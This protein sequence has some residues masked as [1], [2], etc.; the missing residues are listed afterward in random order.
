MSDGPPGLRDLQRELAGLA[1]APATVHERAQAVLERLGRMLPFDAAWLAVR[2]PELGRHSPLATTGPAGPL[3]RYFRTPEADAEVDRLGLNGRRPPMLVGE[4]PVPLPELRA[5]AE[6]LLP[7][8]F[9]GGLAAGLFTT[10]GRHVGFLSLLSEDPDRPDRPHRDVVAAVTSIIADGLDRTRQISETARVVAAATAGVVLTRGGEVLRLPGLPDHRLLTRGS[11]VLSTATRELGGT[12]ALISF[13]VPDR[14]DGGAL[15][16]VTALDC[17][18]P[19]L[20]HLAAAV[21]LGPPGDLRGLTTLDL[22]VLGLLVEGTSTVPAIAAALGVDPRL[23]GDS[24]AASCVA[25]SAPDVTAVAVR[26]LR[27][28]LRIPPRLAG[29]D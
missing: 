3:D 17:A 15:V 20:D 1:A 12:R 14:D 2:D 26:A 16:R 21:L 19:G 13:L 11:P 7:A 18:V 25:L 29:D 5:W 8:G 27:A 6:H 22:L 10:T 4:I 9:R 24:L 28:G 23:V